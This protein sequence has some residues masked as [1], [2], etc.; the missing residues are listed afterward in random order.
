MIPNREE[1]FCVFANATVVGESTLY[2]LMKAALNR[3]LYAVLL[4]PVKG[5]EFMESLLV[6]ND[7]EPLF[8]QLD[9]PMELFLQ[10]SFGK[11]PVIPKFSI[12]GASNCFA[13]CSMI[14][15]SWFWIMPLSTNHKQ[16]ANSLKPGE[17]NY[18]FCHL[19][20]LI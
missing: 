5:K 19:T 15:A 4:T 14:K 17:P 10:H 13:R 20:H 8:W 18:S 3:A 1:V 2:T 6:T 16:R 12:S 11:E 9:Y 7:Q